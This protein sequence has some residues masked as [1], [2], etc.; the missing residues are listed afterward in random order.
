MF[1]FS[2]ASTHTIIRGEVVSQAPDH[3]GGAPTRSFVARDIL[4][5]SVQSGPNAK[6]WTTTIHDD[7]KVVVVTED[8]LRRQLDLPPVPTTTTTL[9]KH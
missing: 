3:R 8:K 5:F 4:A 7:G 1:T 9:K 2:L 6:V